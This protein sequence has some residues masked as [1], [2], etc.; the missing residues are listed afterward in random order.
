MWDCVRQQW[1][2]TKKQS[3]LYSQWQ[4]SKRWRDRSF[5]IFWVRSDPD[6]IRCICWT[7]WPAYLNNWIRKG[8]LWWYDALCGERVTDI[9][10]SQLFIDAWI[11]AP[12]PQGTDSTLQVIWAMMNMINEDTESG[13]TNY[14]RP[15]LTYLKSYVRIGLIGSVAGAWYLKAKVAVFNIAHSSAPVD[16][17]FA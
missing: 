12:W 1:N 7:N 6:F 8:S 4:W 2:A 14:K 9:N 10:S 13:H 11:L 15:T 16:Y 17:A 3:S 5:Q